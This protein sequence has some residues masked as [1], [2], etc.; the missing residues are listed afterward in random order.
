MSPKADQ[1]LQAALE[2]TEQERARVAAERAAS[3]GRSAERRSG[4]GT[5]GDQAD[6]ALAAVRS[7]M[8]ADSRGKWLVLADGALVATVDA[9]ETALEECER[10]FPDGR[11]L[12]VPADERDEFWVPAVIPPPRI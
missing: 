4:A 6:Q 1:L 9:F 12:V 8:P 7:A 3:V 11:A 10:R 2:L 5:P